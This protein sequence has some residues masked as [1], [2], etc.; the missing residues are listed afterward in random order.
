[1]SR[2]LTQFVFFLVLLMVLGVIPDASRAGGPVVGWGDTFSA[3][4]PP[5]SVNGTVGTASAIATGEDFACAIQ[6]ESGNVVCWGENREGQSS[7]PAE[8]DGREGNASSI[9][10]GY[11]HACAI[12]SGTKAM[13]CWGHDDYVQ[14]SP[15]DSVNGIAG[16]A[17]QIAAG[18]DYN[19]AIQAVP[20]PGAG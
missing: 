17:E 7:P 8:V 13:V 20:E 14:A 19:L 2:C 10:A 4:L 15:P 12:Q 18:W 5:D 6:T 3:T 9:A 16:S 11:H 1:M